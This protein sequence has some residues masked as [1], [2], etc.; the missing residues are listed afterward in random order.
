MGF[1]AVLQARWRACRELVGCRC[2]TLRES[3]HI[4]H[5]AA[6]PLRQRR[7]AVGERS[8]AGWTKE[9][10]EAARVRARAAW[11]RLGPEERSAR[12]R[13]VSAGQAGKRWSKERR[14]AHAARMRVRWEAWRSGKIAV[15][16]AQVCVL[17]EMG[18]WPARSG[19]GGK[20][21]GRGDG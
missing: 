2:K 15:S 1:D 14:Q 11:A 18:M 16:A 5:V 13:Q 9:A 17:H 19:P 3:G 20:D 8:R 4:R 6:C 10:R 7:K 12:M 21:G